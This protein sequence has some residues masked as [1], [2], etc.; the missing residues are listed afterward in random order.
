MQLLR[1][2]GAPGSGYLVK[3]PRFRLARAMPGTEMAYRVASRYIG[4]HDA[5]LRRRDDRRYWPAR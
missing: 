4:R 2:R 1:G 5:I 3:K